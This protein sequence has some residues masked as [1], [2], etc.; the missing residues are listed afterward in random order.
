M[1]T[2]GKSAFESCV[3]LESIK[4]PAGLKTIEKEAFFDCE[5]LA[6][7]E[8]VENMEY[9]GKEAFCA[10]T[11][12]SNF[13]SK[14]QA[15]VEEWHKNWDGKREVTTQTVIQDVIDFVNDNLIVIVVIASLVIGGIIVL[16]VL[17]KK[18]RRL[19]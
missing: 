5:K 12:V 6:S 14:K 9:I 8:L 13:E 19:Y 15:N 4:L 2:I 16:Y 7:V 3:K 18:R 1:Q 17:L 10:D 11:V